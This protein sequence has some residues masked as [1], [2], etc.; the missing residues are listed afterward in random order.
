M[1]IIKLYNEQKNVDMSRVESLY[2]DGAVESEIEQ[3]FAEYVGA[4]HACVAKSPYDILYLILQAINVQLYE[5][6]SGS[7]ELQQKAIN[8]KRISIPSNAP[9]AMINSVI[10]SGIPASWEDIPQWVGSPYMIADTSE[11]MTYHSFLKSSIS[12]K[13][14]NEFGEYSSKGLKLIYSG[15][16]SLFA[17]ICFIYVVIA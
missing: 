15:N 16:F 10:N 14:M 6:F 9:I 4:R 1:T 17:R 3:S 12:P 5:G 8:S 7:Q 2:F 11:A 13:K